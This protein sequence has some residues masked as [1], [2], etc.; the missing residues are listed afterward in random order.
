MSSVFDFSQPSAVPEA[1]TCMSTETSGVT[2][3]QVHVEEREQKQHGQQEEGS[4]LFLPEPNHA[5]ASAGDSSAGAG[6]GSPGDVALVRKADLETKGAVAGPAASVS[7]GVSA[8]VVAVGAL[9]C[10]GTERDKEE[11]ESVCLPQNNSTV[12]MMCIDETATSQGTTYVHVLM[13]VY[14]R[15]LL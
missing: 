4:L 6:T 12:S 5:A 2:K 15:L 13:Y 3:A 1:S 8:S 10:G 14:T 11:S 9:M 7:V